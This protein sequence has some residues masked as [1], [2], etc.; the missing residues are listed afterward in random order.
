MNSE[1]SK[2]GSRAVV[3]FFT[4]VDLRA[5]VT[6]YTTFSIIHLDLSCVEVASFALLQTSVP[7]KGGSVQQRY[8]PSPLEKMLKH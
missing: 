4:A 1:K 7:P 2:K 8:L 3:F 5:K 6:I